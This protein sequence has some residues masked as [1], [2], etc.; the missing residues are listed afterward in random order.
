MPRY[1][2]DAILGGKVQLFLR[3]GSSVWWCSTCRRRAAQSVDPG[4]E[5]R[6]RQEFH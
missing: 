1:T 2:N 5:P 3:G 6:S 4:G